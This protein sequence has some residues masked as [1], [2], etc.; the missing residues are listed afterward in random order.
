MLEWE[1]DEGSRDGKIIEGVEEEGRCGDGVR[2][3]QAENAG[4]WK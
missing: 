4:K 3:A 1:G 2:G